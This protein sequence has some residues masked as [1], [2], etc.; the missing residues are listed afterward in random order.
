M[1]INGSAQQVNHP[2]ELMDTIQKELE[3][4]NMQEGREK[5]LK[6]GTKEYFEILM[7]QE[8]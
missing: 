6:Y 2:L 7:I 3:L 4:D 1:E 5:L 8:N